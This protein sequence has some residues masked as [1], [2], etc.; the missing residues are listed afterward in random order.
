MSPWIWIPIWPSGDASNLQ[1]AM[2]MPPAPSCRKYHGSLPSPV[3][4]YVKPRNKIVC[5]QILLSL[6]FACARLIT[7]VVSQIPGIKVP[8]WLYLSPAPGPPP[9]V[10]DTHSNGMFSRDGIDEQAL[11]EN[12]H[13]LTNPGHS[14]QEH[15]EVAELGVS[16]Q[17]Y[18][19]AR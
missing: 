5:R 8:G 15:T 6:G 16:G 7:H 4:P 14:C 10:T 9:E 11:P 1:A 17:I 12:K 3:S 19:L 2:V 18:S 13:D